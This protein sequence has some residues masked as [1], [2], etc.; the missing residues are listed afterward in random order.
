MS[1][2]AGL[3]S[4]LLTRVSPVDCSFPEEGRS[5]SPGKP[6]PSS[7]LAPK[8]C[9]LMGTIEERQGGPSSCRLHPLCLLLALLRSLKELPPCPSVHQ[10]DQTQHGSTAPSTVQPLLGTLWRGR[11]KPLGPPAHLRGGVNGSPW[12]DVQDHSPSLLSRPTSCSPS[13]QLP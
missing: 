10:C 2:L 7:S 12:P 8:H 6:A 9:G 4:E 11:E 3:Q 1:P 13:S 5:Y